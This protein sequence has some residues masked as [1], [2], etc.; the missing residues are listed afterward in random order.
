[1]D[2]IPKNYIRFFFSTCSHPLR[3][4]HSV[5]MLYAQ[6]RLPNSCFVVITLYTSTFNFQSQ[7]AHSYLRASTEGL[8]AASTAV[9][10]RASAP[11]VL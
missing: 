9:V 5:H 4:L 6:D 8:E 11:T 3:R 10:G 2:E 7:E 1:M